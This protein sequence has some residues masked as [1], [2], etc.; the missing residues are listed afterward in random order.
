MA[1]FSIEQELGGL[2]LKAMEC[3]DAYPAGRARIGDAIL[4]VEVQ[5]L[6]VE[7][8]QIGTSTHYFATTRRSVV[9]RGLVESF[10]SGMN[11]EEGFDDDEELELEGGE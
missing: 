5:I 2:A 1:D 3:L 9:Q 4:L 10:R 8:Q 7:D 6:D 11:A